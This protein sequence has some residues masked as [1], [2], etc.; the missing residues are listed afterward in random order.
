LNAA[1][2]PAMLAV[3]L[4]PFVAG[5]VTGLTVGFVG[6]SF[7]FVIALMHAPASGLTPQATLVLAY[8]CG[9]LGL[10]LSPVHLCLLLSREYFKAPFSG[11]YRLLV[12]PTLLVFLFALAGYGVFTWLGI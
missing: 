6:T 9:Y 4:L 5:L 7:P 8:G 1:H 3:M 12:A 11:V 10:L 2:V